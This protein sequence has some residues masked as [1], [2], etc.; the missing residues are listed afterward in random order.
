[1]ADKSRLYRTTGDRLVRAQNSAQARHFV[2]RS[3]IVVAVATQDDIV[4]LIGK[5]VMVEDASP[6]SDK[7]L[8]LTA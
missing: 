2:S 4:E 1:V 8:D 7:Q 6:E 5:G 3:T